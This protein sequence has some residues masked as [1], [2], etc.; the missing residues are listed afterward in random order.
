M[1]FTSA[2]YVLDADEY[3]KL[4]NRMS[5]FQNETNV[6]EAI[7]ITLICGN[8]YKRKYSGFVR[9]VIL[10]DDLFEHA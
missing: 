1:K 10:G 5:Q 7:H 4:R 6:K 2:D 3:E 9:N 8:G